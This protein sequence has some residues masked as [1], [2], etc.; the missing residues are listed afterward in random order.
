MG[1][2]REIGDGGAAYGCVDNDLYLNITCLHC[3]LCF[4]CILQTDISR[5]RLTFCLL[6]ESISSYISL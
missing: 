4:I 5:H 1:D 6:L 3:M 2:G